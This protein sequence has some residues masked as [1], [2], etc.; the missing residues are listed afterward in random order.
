M[1]EIICDDKIFDETINFMKVLMSNKI[2]KTY[3]FDKTI[4]FMK[5][6]MSNKIYKT[7]DF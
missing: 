6:L 1:S 3:D 7:Y 4:N 5:V 2:Y